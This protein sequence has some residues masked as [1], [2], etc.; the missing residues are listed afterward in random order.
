M[1][2]RWQDYFQPGETL[3]W[4]GA[5]K[6][7]VHGKVK[8]IALALFGLPFLI[9]GLGVFATGV[10]MAFGGKTWGDIGLGLFFAAFAVP[11]AGVG[12]L[13]VVGQ[14]WAAARAHAKIRYALSSR[15]A[16][17]AKT[18][19]THSIESY[20]ILKSTATGLEKGRSAD[21]VWFH[22]RSERGADGDRSTTRIGFDNIADGDSVYRL[23]RS[24]QT[25]ST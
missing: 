23:I 22:V 8:I 20:P 5:P 13:M 16:Y 1:A 9:I 6:P 10:G 11:F 7:G 4:E 14:W 24:I 2:G 15:A 17:I 25:G 3:L 12:A 21:T 19:W 18:Y